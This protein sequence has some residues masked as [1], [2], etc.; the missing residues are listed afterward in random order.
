MKSNRFT[1]QRE[2]QQVVLA[3]RRYVWTQY[4]GFLTTGQPD[5]AARYQRAHSALL[6]ASRWDFLTSAVAS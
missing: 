2:L 6:R 5:L 4:L 3:R 1:T